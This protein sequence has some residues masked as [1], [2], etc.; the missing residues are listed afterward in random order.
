MPDTILSSTARR[1]RETALAV[2]ASAGFPD[3]VRFTRQLYLAGPGTYI[4][5]LR[6]LPDACG[7]AMVVGHNP[8]MEE[9]V[10]ALTGV[11]ESMP[12][13]ALA[14]VELPIE[15]WPDLGPS[16]GGSLRSTWKP[17]D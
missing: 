10:A 9:L 15:S 8:G 3:E 6:E 12:T 1:A 4:E 2:V 16:P 5:T 14:V 13:A 7:H 17:R 11:S